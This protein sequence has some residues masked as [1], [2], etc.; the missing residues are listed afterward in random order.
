MSLKICCNLQVLPGMETKYNI[1]TLH[2]KCYLCICTK[3]G[4]SGAANNRDSNGGIYV[5][6]RASLSRE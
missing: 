5:F 2:G 6:L 3:H 1:Q 4:Y